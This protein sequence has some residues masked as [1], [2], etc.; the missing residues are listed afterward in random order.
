MA[1]SRL[2]CWD[3]FHLQRPGRSHCLMLYGWL[4]IAALFQSNI[5]MGKGWNC[6][7]LKRNEVE[8][9]IATTLV[10]GCSYTYAFRQD[11]NKQKHS[12]IKPLTNVK[13]KFKFNRI[14]IFL[15]KWLQVLPTFTPPKKENWVNCLL[16]Y[17]KISWYYTLT[18]IFQPKCVVSCSIHHMAF[19]SLV[20][21]LSNIL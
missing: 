16:I 17:L 1:E 6:L 4:I 12:Y 19:T 8:D 2:H 9:K 10:K 11:L 21:F 18:I 20:L 13:V 3:I 5:Y 14:Q 7:T 15:S